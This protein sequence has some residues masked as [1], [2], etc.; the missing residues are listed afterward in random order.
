[1][2]TLGGQDTHTTAMIFK[3]TKL[4]CIS[5]SVVEI[6]D[7]LPTLFA[8]RFAELIDDVKSSD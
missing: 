3:T 5:K 4:G 8:I 6:C 1:M 7:S 2:G